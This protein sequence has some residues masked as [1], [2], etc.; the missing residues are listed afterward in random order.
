MIIAWN[1]GFRMFDFEFYNLTFN[2]LDLR[3]SIFE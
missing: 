2:N 3:Y 1:V